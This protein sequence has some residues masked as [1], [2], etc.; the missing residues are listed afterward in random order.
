[1]G[2]CQHTSGSCPTCGRVVRH[3]RNQ[4]NLIL[5]VPSGKLPTDAE[6]NPSREEV[7]RKTQRGNTCSAQEVA[8]LTDK[9]PTVHQDEAATKPGAPGALGQDTSRT[10]NPST[11]P[12]AMEH[13]RGISD[14]DNGPPSSPTGGI[15]DGESAGDNPRGQSI[16]TCAIPGQRLARKTQRGNT[17]SAQQVAQITAPSLPTGM[18]SAGWASPQAGIPSTKP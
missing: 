14:S 8:H 5:S 16:P 15:Q 11:A 2:Q 9:I 10:E 4:S 6:D 18:R 13:V 3:K 7:A 12:T 1:M 17:G